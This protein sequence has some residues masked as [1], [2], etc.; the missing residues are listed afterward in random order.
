MPALD[1][2]IPQQAVVELRK[3]SGSLGKRRVGPAMGNPGT[4]DRLQ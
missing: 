4:P 3:I 2:A 1:A